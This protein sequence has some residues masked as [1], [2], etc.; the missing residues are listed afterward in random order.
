MSGGGPRERLC[1]RE[2]VTQLVD[3]DRV[4]DVSAAPEPLGPNSRKLVRN[5]QI[6]RTALYPFFLGSGKAAHEPSRRTGA[7]GPPDSY[8]A[9]NFTVVS[10]GLTAQASVDSKLKF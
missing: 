7:F 1:L 6:H 10:E 9:K 4:N 2:S 3:F 8:R 5:L